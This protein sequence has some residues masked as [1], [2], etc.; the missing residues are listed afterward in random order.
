MPDMLHQD[1]FDVRDGSLRPNLLSRLRIQLRLEPTIT[2]IFG[3][4]GKSRTCY[5]TRGLVFRDYLQSESGLRLCPRGRVA[6]P[7]M[8]WYSL[9]DRAICPGYY[10]TR[11]F[12]MMFA[13]QLV[14][15]ARST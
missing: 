4:R 7:S 2:S 1:T 3:I 9:D 15:T 14:A 12:E 6:I 11:V 5:Q 10:E 8:M 13:N